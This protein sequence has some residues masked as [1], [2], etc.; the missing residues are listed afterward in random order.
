MNTTYK[1]LL[2]AL[3]TSNLVVSQNNINFKDSVFYYLKEAYKFPLNVYKLKLS[4]QY[5]NTDS[6]NLSLFTNLEDLNL[7]YDSL[8]E[9][10]K[11][12]EKSK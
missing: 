2:L 1:I 5:L 10:P 4:N 6:L 7:S 3:L 11:G 9:L 8:V 12:L